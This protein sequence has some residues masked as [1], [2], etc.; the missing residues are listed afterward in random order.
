M[1]VLATSAAFAQGGAPAAATQ[2]SAEIKGT[3]KDA[4]GLPVADAK[5]T[6]ALSADT[7]ILPPDQP[8][9]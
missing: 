3:V 5:V 1:L 8:D 7:R 2:G 9:G 6:F 4:A